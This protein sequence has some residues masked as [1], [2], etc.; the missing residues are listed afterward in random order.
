MRTTETS[1]DQNNH[2]FQN[3]DTRISWMPPTAEVRKLADQI[4]Q[5]ISTVAGEKNI[6]LEDIYWTLDNIDLARIKD[7]NLPLTNAIAQVL[8]QNKQLINGWKE[9][10]IMAKLDIWRKQNT[11]QDNQAIIQRIKTM[12]RH[13]KI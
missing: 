4:L 1:N 11:Q 5:A 10:I 6:D 2:P 12:L 13:L 8:E 3:P 9:A 7:F